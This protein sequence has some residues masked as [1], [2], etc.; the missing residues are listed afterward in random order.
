MSMIA[1]YKK[2]GGFL[3]LLNLLETSGFA[4][5]EKF[6]KLIEEEDASWAHAIKSK[7]L[8]VKQIFTWDDDIVATIV[9]QAN[10]LTIATALFSLD[11]AAKEK[12]FKMMS[13]ARKR[14]IEDLRSGK[15]PTPAE[16][17]SVYIQILTDVRRLVSEGHIHLEKIDP[18]LVVEHEIEDKLSQGTYFQRTPNHEPVVGRSEKVQEASHEKTSAASGGDLSKYTKEIENL[19]RQV[20]QLMAENLQ[21]KEKLAVVEGKLASI[22]KNAA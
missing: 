21:L 17:S 15:E 16:S 9:A 20:S 10:D 18:A 22:R 3:Q 12:T 5:Q 4:K 8:T 19:K 13:H 7:M 14:K 1:R 6:L 11:E 2:K